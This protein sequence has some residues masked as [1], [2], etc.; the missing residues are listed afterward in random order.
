MINGEKERNK[1]SCMR[2]PHIAHASH[3]EILNH[4]FVIV[5][6]TRPGYQQVHVLKHMIRRTSDVP[7]SYRAA[8]IPPLCISLL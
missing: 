5:L 3:N 2:A 8:D 7:A 1:K 4:L 6:V